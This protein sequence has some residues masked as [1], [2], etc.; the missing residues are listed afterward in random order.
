M[1]GKMTLFVGIVLSLGACTNTPSP[2]NTTPSNQAQCTALRTELLQSP[3]DTNDNTPSAIADGENAS[4]QQL[5][6]HQCE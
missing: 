3:M 2:Q 5:Y 6:H 4:T 1:K